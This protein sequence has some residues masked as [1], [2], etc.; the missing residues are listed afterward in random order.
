MTAPLQLDVRLPVRPKQLGVLTSIRFFA[1]LAV[2]FFHVG[3]TPISNVSASLGLVFN[4]GY[5]A[6]G[7]FYVLSGFVLAYNYAGLKVHGRAFYAARFARLYP[8]YFLALVLALPIFLWKAFGSGEHPIRL[9]A[10]FMLVPPML[11]AWLPQTA[12]AWNTPAWS[13]SVE[14]FFY[15]LFP[16]LIH[17]ISWRSLR[18]C[19]W[20][21]ATMWIAAILPSIFYAMARPDGL[22]VLTGIHQESWIQAETGGW[23]GVVN[24]SPLLR[25]PEFVAGVALGCA[26]KKHQEAKK[27]PEAR[28]NT[29]RYPVATAL[30]LL[31]ILLAVRFLPE[32][33]PYPI[34]HNGLLLPLWC[35]LIYSV[36]AYQ[37]SGG[38]VRL[39]AHPGL[40]L[41]GEASYGIYIL[42]QPVS[43]WVKLLLLKIGG[44]NIKGDYPSVALLLF[45]CLILC[46][47]SILSFRRLELPLR[48]W[49]REKL[50][51]SAPESKTKEQ[52]QSHS[53]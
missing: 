25:L 15:L 40:I 37:D 43:G 48:P 24:F 42:Q 33:V 1:A 3:F 27:D 16:W 5:V 51:K 8:V 49:L 20:I 50:E 12:L 45:Y 44:V 9:V 17:S 32:W 26:F 14:C 52:P 6:V 31:T 13:I 21:A 2:V 10:S 29:L 7:L 34:M 46:G 47:A 28:T 38:Y 35:I 36:A 23:L 19:I 39:L 18:S 53:A 41:L 30:S 4:S 11:Q 22:S